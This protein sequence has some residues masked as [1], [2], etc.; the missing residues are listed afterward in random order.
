MVKTIKIFIC[1]IVTL[2]ALEQAHSQRINK[3]ELDLLTK[4]LD[5]HPLLL[6][7]DADFK[8]LKKNSR[9]ESESAII[10]CKKTGF[11]F[12]KK[13]LSAGKRIGRNIWAAIF[14]IPT[15]GTS[16][17]MAN[18]NN[19]TRILIEETERCK[20]QL[21][22]KFAVE[23]YAILYFRLSFEG[24]AFAAQVIKKDGSKQKVDLSNSARVA[25]LKS[26]PT[27]FRSYT[28]NRLS[29]AYRPEYFKIAVPDLEEGDI[30]EYE[31][32]NFNN[33]QYSYNPKYKEFD[34]VYYLCNRELP[35]AK[36]IIEIATKD[37]KYYIGYKNLKG[38]PAFTQT[39]NKDEKVYR[40]EDNDREKITDTRYV[41]ELMELPSIKFQVVYARN[42]SKG[43][44]WFKDEN[45]MKR[46]MSNEELAQKAKLFWF[47][48]DR[49]QST[50]D[51]TAGLKASINATVKSMYKTLKKSG[52]TET[53]EDDYVRK[54]YYLIRA[55]TL[56]NS[57]SDFAFAKVFSGLLNEKR[58]GHD[59]VLSASNEKS[60]LSNI[61]FT[62]EISWAVK[63]KNKYYCN[64]YEHLNP[65]ELPGFLSG[66]YGIRFSNDNEKAP[67][68]DEV[69]PLLDTSANLVT[70]TIKAALD[71]GAAM[72]LTIE[73]NVEARGLAKDVINEDVLAYTPF[74]ESDYKN[75]DGSGMW[76]GL[77]SAQEEKASS[78]F[79]DEKKQW[80]HEKIKMMKSLAESE[81]GHDVDKYGSF[82]L[83]QDGREYKK[84][85]LKY[86]ESFTLSE[87]TATAGDDKIISIGGLIG[88]QT[89]IKK[90]ELKRTLPIDVSYPRTL[91]WNLIF[92]LPPGFTAKGLSNLTKNINNSC[93]AFTSTAKIEGNN[94]V[95]NAKKI[96][97]SKNYSI[98]Q[99]P[100]IIEMLQAAYDFSQ[101]KIILQR[102]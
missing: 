3:R 12:D 25:D 36:Q 50:G 16:F 97:R 42:S 18:A 5:A 40:W 85:D 17:I 29:S 58:I 34:P 88:R 62:Q 94:L 99:W 28:D 41:N 78:V 47:E 95:I 96:Y 87:M 7:T 80:K 49:V 61:A 24:D 46:E 14:A 81:Y 26:I 15:L 4:N 92:S 91:T 21:N 60:T 51:Y 23:Q 77:N 59:I 84:K 90:E 73:K 1:I 63:Y 27:L 13:G 37:D 54:A 6:E 45:D 2:I 68:V 66:N 86:A 30:I 55:Q 53:T 71:T 32:V 56:Y 89:K 48:P 74:M 44:V 31:F 52:I 10:L 64:P 57:W 82:R 35:V 11:E 65:E 79:A 9:W 19:D 8:D 101:T 98:E 38:A 33:S 93:G 43:F 39:N 70:T 22:D 72:N 102:Q 20:I 69:L 83:L 76:E 67:A 100:Q 75:Y